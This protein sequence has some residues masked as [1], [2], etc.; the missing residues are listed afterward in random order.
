M[1][2]KLLDCAYQ[3]LR[4][5]TLQSSHKRI[6]YPVDK[7]VYF[8]PQQNPSAKYWA[9]SDVKK[10]HTHLAQDKYVPFSD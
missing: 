9:K 5:Q 6:I 3:I 10:V 7:A 8:V 4:S 1:G 2:Q